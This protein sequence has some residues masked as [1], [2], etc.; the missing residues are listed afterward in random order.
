M[1]TGF[2]EA[3]LALAIFPILVQGIGLWFEGLSMMNRMWCWKKTLENILRELDTERVLYHNTCL[4]LLE[5][6][7]YE[8]PIEDLM[9]GDTEFKNM[10]EAHMGKD[11]ARA[12]LNEASQLLGLLKELLNTLKIDKHG[13]PECDSKG[14]IK[15]STR[16]IIIKLILK[17]DENLPQLKEIC[18]INS[19]IERL[20]PRRIT[21]NEISG[22]KGAIP[23][24]AYRKFQKYAFN[25]HSVLREKLSGPPCKCASAH[26]VSLQLLKRI[27]H[28]ALPS[29]RGQ[30]KFTLLFSY[31]SS[32]IVDT[33]QQCLMEFEPVEL[34]EPPSPNAESSDPATPSSNEQLS[35]SSSSTEPKK[36]RKSVRF[37]TRK[38]NPCNNKDDTMNTGSK[39]SKVLGRFRSSEGNGSVNTQTP[40]PNCINRLY[41]NPQKQYNELCPIILEVCSTNK[42]HDLGILTA[43]DCLHHMR[44]IESQSRLN[45]ISLRK[46]L[47][48]TTPPRI[49]DTRIRD[50]L[51]LGLT[52]ASAAIQL[53]GTV[54]LNDRW[55]SDDICFL[56][57]VRNAAQLDGR[58]VE[59]LEPLLEQ[60]LVRYDFQ[61]SVSSS[62]N[63]SETSETQPVFH[64]EF[65]YSL[66]W[67]LME[68]L[69][70]KPREK[71]DPE[72]RRLDSRKINE[73]LWEI[74]LTAGLM[75]SE[76]I[77]RCLKGFGIRYTGVKNL[78]YQKKLEEFVVSKLQDHFDRFSD[79]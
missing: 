77:E 12:F 25:L 22:H 52:L 61:P 43:K 41:E 79:S 8:G 51:Q 47:E 30:M 60:P 7:G 56:Q 42:F 54:W 48:G 40:A 75:Y 16:M 44:S 58:P 5:A 21:T 38:K 32:S 33:V 17:R 78:D 26:T 57:E 20:A 11:I 49:R 1:P 67:I 34:D 4:S 71:I 55:G 59:I 6:C 53:H 74:K 64:D 69:F 72:W 19:R 28:T 14:R 65:L 68:L 3:G 23:T 10:L 45:T 46:L 39:F 29:E 13:R 27:T 70:A 31:K 50:R 66:G 63:I 18:T 2:E 9:N 15:N 24:K 62:T 35:V 37:F 76:A 73:H 36:T